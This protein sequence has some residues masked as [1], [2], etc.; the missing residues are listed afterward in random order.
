MALRTRVLPVHLQLRMA[1]GKV[2][3]YLTFALPAVGKVKLSYTRH[4]L[5]YALY[6]CSPAVFV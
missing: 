6:L 2:L 3:P 4:Y 5:W 1:I